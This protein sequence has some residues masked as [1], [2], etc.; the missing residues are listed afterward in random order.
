V[1]LNNCVCV[2]QGPELAL[3][4]LTLKSIQP[5]ATHWA[6]AVS[7]LSFTPLANATLYPCFIFIFVTDASYGFKRLSLSYLPIPNLSSFLP[8]SS[9]ALTVVLLYGFVYTRWRIAFH[10]EA[11]L[12][13]IGGSDFRRSISFPTL[14]HS[15]ALVHRPDGASI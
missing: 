13:C 12:R 6:P 10:R 2:S 3:M 1:K 14:N 11:T 8:V 7:M 9:L 4:F 15:T 5:P